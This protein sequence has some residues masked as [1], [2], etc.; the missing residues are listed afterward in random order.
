[1]YRHPAHLRVIVFAVWKKYQKCSSMCRTSKIPLTDSILKC[2][3]ICAA[4]GA[5]L[6]LKVRSGFWRSPPEFTFRLDSHGGGVYCVFFD[7]AS[8][9]MSA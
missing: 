7:V 2:I 1:T 3:H 4:L 8:K 6:R 5:A 9:D